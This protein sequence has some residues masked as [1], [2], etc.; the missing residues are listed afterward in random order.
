MRDRYGSIAGQ[1]FSYGG[2]FGER[3]NLYDP[4]L[5]IYGDFKDDMTLI[6]NLPPSVAL[7]RLGNM[8]KTEVTVVRSGQCAN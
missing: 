6:I 4:D 7:E 5:S 1:F 2:S 8:N 3:S